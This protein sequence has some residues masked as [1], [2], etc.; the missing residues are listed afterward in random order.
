MH[1]HED[2]YAYPNSQHK[3]SFAMFRLKIFDGGNAYGMD[4]VKLKIC[5]HSHDQEKRKRVF[6]LNVF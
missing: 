6:S 1:R 4:Y 2:A 5:A 3:G